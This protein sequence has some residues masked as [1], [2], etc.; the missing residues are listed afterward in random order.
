MPE[1]VPRKDIGSAL[2]AIALVVMVAA[3]ALPISIELIRSLFVLQSDQ[4][5]VS[6]GEIFLSTP[7]L[8]LLVRSLAIAGGIGLVGMCMGIPLARVIGAGI[9]R[10]GALLIGVLISPIWLPATMVYAAG[11]LLRAP[12]T[13]VGRAIVTFSTSDESLRWVTIWVGYAIAVL[14]LAIWSAPIAAILIASGLGHRSSL[15]DEMIALEPIGRVRR[16]RLW[17]GINRTPLLRAWALLTVLMLGSA[18]PMHLAQL[19]TWS[20]VIWRELAESPIEQW[21][22][23]WLSSWPMVIAA[24]LGAWLL[25][26]TLI[27]DKESSSL[28]DHGHHRVRL[29]RSVR[30]SAIGV[31]ILGAIVPMAAMLVSLDDWRSILYFWTLEA[32]ALR[33]SG[34]VALL[35]GG[36][37]MILAMLVAIT[38]GS[39]ARRIRRAGAGAVLVLCILGL[40]PGVLVGAAIARTP[41]SGIHA[42]L[43]GSIAGAVLG[44]FIRVGFLG[45]IIGALCA[46][47]ESIERKSLRWQLAGGSIRGWTRAALP[48]IA[49]P[50]LG[51]GLVG[52]LY[53]MYEIEASVMIRPPGM[54]NLPQQILSDLHYARLEQLSAAGINLLAIGLILSIIASVF[55]A[56]VQRS[57]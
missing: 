6:L 29:P 43:S 24:A 8:M 39:P 49:L 46:R 57:P 30:S 51:V 55:L 4:S 5:G 15:Y 52:F 25:T 3:L 18:V 7:R 12:D 10:R 11:N 48:G 31:W 9:T 33:D 13:I 14:G 56:R 27:A 35:A 20:I 22:V 28:E 53:S 41:I 1:Q 19:E 21:G 38:L 37:T 36:F 42:S 50:V 47:S 45:A 44:S 17:V 2:P 26:H 34:F 16:A 54:A 40:I 23:V 32:D